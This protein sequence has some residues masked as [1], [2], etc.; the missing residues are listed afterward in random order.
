MLNQ[1]SNLI[2]NCCFTNAGQNSHKDLIPLDATPAINASN[3][4]HEQKI[5]YKEEI[6]NYHGEN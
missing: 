6:D 1:I 4:T 3:K 5:Y 2:P